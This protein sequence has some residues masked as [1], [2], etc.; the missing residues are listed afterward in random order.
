M[1]K[2]RVMASQQGDLQMLCDEGLVHVEAGRVRLT[3]SGKAVSDRIAEI[4][5]PDA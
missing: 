3:R 2:A 4:L 1:A 5:I